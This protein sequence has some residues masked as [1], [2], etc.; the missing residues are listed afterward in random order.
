MS[1]FLAVAE[2]G[3]VSKAAR[4]LN[5]TQPAL[6][7]NIRVLE[8]HLEASLF[9]RHAGGVELTVYG[10]MLAR[11]ARLM[12]LE[13]EHARS[14]IENF[15]GGRQ[16]H[17]KIGAIPA[18]QT[19]YIPEAISA[20]RKELAG[21]NFS[22]V[23]DASRPL[24]AMLREGKLDIACLA[25]EVQVYPDVV[26]EPLLD[27]ERVVMCSA[28]HPLAKRK[29]VSASD[30]LEFSWTQMKNDELTVSRLGGYFSAFDLAPPRI[31]VECDSNMSMLSILR[32]TELLG[33][34]PKVIADH[35][36]CDGLVVLP[37]QGS[38]WRYKTGIAYRRESS[39]PKFLQSFIS[40]I[41][42]YVLNEA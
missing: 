20:A 33:T 7:R 40:Y 41:R 30:L 19:I 15:K 21:V 9:E 37:I 38:L 16:G 11:R 25:L 28:R 34:A 10:Q 31:D 12:M 35:P 3:G 1:H 4:V 36:I 29:S 26:M 42:A 39:P 17:I 18:W 24:L 14:E 22:V 32:S 2:Q 27:M 23:G 6:T 8:Q 5:I 13:F